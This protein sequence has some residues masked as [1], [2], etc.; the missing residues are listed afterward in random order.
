MYS[1]LGAAVESD[2]GIGQVDTGKGKARVHLAAWG[3]VQSK[4]N[5]SR[6]INVM[7]TE[8][9]LETPTQPSPILR[10]INFLI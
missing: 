1:G 4:L 10:K 8:P 5:P 9:L 7:G 3:Y 2:D 6:Y